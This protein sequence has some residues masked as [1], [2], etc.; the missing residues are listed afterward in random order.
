MGI[1]EV[2]TAPRSPWQSPYVE[3]IIGSIRRECLDH[4]II[5]NET[6]LRGVLSCYFG[7]YHKSRT[8]LALNKD[9]PA[10]RRIRPPSAGKIVAFPEVGDLHYRYE[11]RAA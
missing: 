9:C 6:H 8:H 3:R 7:Y 5:F 10:A 4:V 11:R 1:Q 2:L